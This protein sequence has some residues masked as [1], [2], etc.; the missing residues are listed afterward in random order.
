MRWEPLV[1]SSVLLDFPK[2]SELADT[3]SSRDM[4]GWGQR[5]AVPLSGLSLLV[6]CFL[7]VKAQVGSL[8]PW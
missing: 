1:V 8:S 3:P 6:A 7:V 4:Q 5:S 2:T